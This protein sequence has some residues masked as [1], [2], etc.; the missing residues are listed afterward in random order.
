MGGLIYMILIGLAAG[1]L[2]KY[3]SPGD[4]PGNLNDFQG[5]LITC[6]IGIVGSLIGG[7]VGKIIGLNANGF[8]GQIV[9]A[10]VGALIFLWAYKK[11]KEK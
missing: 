11:Y 10:T 2:A 9:L 6:I 3:L 1:A 5:L 8:I 4:E 7:L